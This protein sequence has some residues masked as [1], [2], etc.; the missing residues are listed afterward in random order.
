[1][2][3]NNFKQ[4]DKD[5]PDIRNRFKVDPKNVRSVV[6]EELGIDPTL[7]RYEIKNDQLYHYHGVE[8]KNILSVA[9]VSY[10][11]YYIECCNQWAHVLAGEDL[12]VTDTTEIPFT[13]DEQREKLKDFKPKKKQQTDF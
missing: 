13:L 4:Q 3:L 8:P 12:K 10:I 2:A 11:S 5:K 1:M 9:H 6:A 7:P